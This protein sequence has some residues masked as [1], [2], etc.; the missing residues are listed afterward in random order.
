MMMAG[1]NTS[2]S[3]LTATLFYLVQYPDV[4]KTLQ[5]DLRASFP[6]VASI[7]FVA[8]ENHRYLRACIDEAMRLSPPAPTNISRVVG[9]G[10]TKVVNEQL[11]KNVYVGVSNFSVFRK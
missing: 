5:A 6:T 1:S 3:S 7:Q 4:L 2:S 11:S 8:A 9:D 10:G